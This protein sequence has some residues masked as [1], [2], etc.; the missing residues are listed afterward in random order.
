MK[1]ASPILASFLIAS[2]LA[3]ALLY[4]SIAQ[5]RPNDETSTGY[6]RT[7]ESFY[8]EVNGSAYSIGYYADS[9]NATL[10]L[11]GNYTFS[12]P[13][14]ISAKVNITSGALTINGQ[15]YKVLNGSG[16]FNTKNGLIQINCK[17]E[18]N[19]NT[20]ELILHGR[21][22]STTGEVTFFSP[23]SKLASQFFFNFEGQAKSENWKNGSTT[24]QGQGHG[25]D[26]DKHNDKGQGDDE[27]NS[28]GHSG[29]KRG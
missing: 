29:H 20:Y 9:R 13:K 11:N 10:L 28:R 14:N 2:L 27:E 1:T 21:I 7:L 8:L 22:D 24:A 3:L 23:Q 17:V 5:A 16:V 6:T 18:F 26:K 25:R 19:G 12:N 15:T 4:Q